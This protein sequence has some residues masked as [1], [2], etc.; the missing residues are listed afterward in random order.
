MTEEYEEINYQDRKCVCG[1]SV[2]RINRGCMVHGVI[3]SGS[4]TFV[5]NNSSQCG[6]TIEF[7]PDVHGSGIETRFTT[8]HRRVPDKK[9][10]P[11]TYRLHEAL[12]GDDYDA[13]VSLLSIP[14]RIFPL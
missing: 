14:L 11:N 6:D 8:I 3:T 12:V 7:R 13:V 10:R 5:C 2:T 9:A 4:V 1:G